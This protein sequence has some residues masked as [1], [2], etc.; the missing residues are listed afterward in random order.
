MR[1]AGFDNP[2]PVKIAIVLLIGRT[3]GS[4]GR[5]KGDAR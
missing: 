3:E 1:A 2:L 5:L 4:A